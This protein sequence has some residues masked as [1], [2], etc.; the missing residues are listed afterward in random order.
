TQ[1]KAALIALL[2]KVFSTRTT[3]E[4][5]AILKDFPDFIFETINRVSDLDRDPQF[6]ANDYI[7]E[8]PH[9]DTGKLKMVGIPVK[10]SDTPGQIRMP[11]PQLGQH[12]EEVLTD[13]CG[14]SWEEVGQLAE[15]GVI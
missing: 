14:F 4:W 5:V 9:P 15:Q 12:T 8:V 13:I 10:F 1:N 3:Q 11:A 2:N 6:L 7:V